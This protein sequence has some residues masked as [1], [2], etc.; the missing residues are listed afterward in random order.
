MKISKKPSIKFTTLLFAGMLM[1]NN[2]ISFATTVSLG[3]ET[4][5]VTAGETF[6]LDLIMD[7]GDDQVGAGVVDIVF[8]DTFIRFQS[9]AFDADF[10]HVGETIDPQTSELVSIGFGSD[11]QFP[12]TGGPFKVGTLS[13]LATSEPGVS[14]ITLSRSPKWGGFTGITLETIDTVVGVQAV[15]LPGAVWFLGSSLIGLISLNRRKA[16]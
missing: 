9:F 10:T 16:S 3:A 15:P 14:P 5:Q 8:D 11:P 13:F 2:S 12:L 4:K 1:L 6:S 7:F